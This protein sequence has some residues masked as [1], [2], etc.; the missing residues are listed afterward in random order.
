MRG[1]HQR[2]YRPENL[3]LTVTGQINEQQLFEAVRPIEEKILRKEVVRNIWRLSLGEQVVEDMER[4]WQG[5]LKPAGWTEER[6]EGDDKNHV[7]QMEY[8]SDDES[9]GSVTVAWRL[10]QHI[11]EDTGR[12]EALRLVADYLSL[13]QVSPLTKFYV[14]TSEPL[15]SSVSHSMSV[16][17]GP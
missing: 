9:K 6:P 10:G 5:V 14:E 8:P 15:A 12:L 17:S 3:I 16:I 2:F 1:Y 13:S 7:F 4:P 11:T